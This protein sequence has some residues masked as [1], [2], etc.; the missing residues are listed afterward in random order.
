MIGLQE[1]LART[2]GANPRFLADNQPER[3]LYTTMG[4][5]VWITAAFSAAALPAALSLATGRFNPI[6]LL[7]GAIWG[8]FIFNL[9]R[10]IVSAVDHVT[11]S[12]NGRT[13]KRERVA[14]HCPPGLHAGDQC[15]DRPRQGDREG[16]GRKQCPQQRER[17]LS[18]RRF[19]K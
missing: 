11:L 3:T 19:A 7:F 1:R 13:T 8:L 12:V 4:Q 6:F 5:S 18:D 10:W 16:P 14:Y 17:S 9:D 2:A 15:P